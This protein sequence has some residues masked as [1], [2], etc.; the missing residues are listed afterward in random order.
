MITKEDVKHIAKLSKLNF[1]EEELSS[2]TVEIDKIVEYVNTI[3][4]IDIS[5]VD[6]S[7]ATIDAKTELREDTPR[8][9]LSQSEAIANAS[10]K[11]DGAFSVPTIIE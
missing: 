3:A 9:S 5:T 11:E 8:A 6:D 1:T 7:V 4:N 10:V 2:F